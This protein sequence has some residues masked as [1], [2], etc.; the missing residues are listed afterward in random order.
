V[1]LRLI[2]LEFY[3]L[4]RNATAFHINSFGDDLKIKIIYLG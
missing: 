3:R 1:C 2:Y 4:Q